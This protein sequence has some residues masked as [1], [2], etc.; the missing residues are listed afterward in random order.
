MLGE[1]IETPAGTAVGVDVFFVSAVA[2]TPA[3]A[4]P[5]TARAIHNHLCPFGPTLAVEARASGESERYS[6]QV[7]PARVFPLSA[8]T[9]TS[10]EPAVWFHCI[11]QT[12]ARPSAPVVTISVFD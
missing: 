7:V 6:E 5:P 11:P 3:A 12:P 2:A 8:V 10:S 9:R 4:A 1:P